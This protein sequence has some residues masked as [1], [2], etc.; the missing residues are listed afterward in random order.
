MSLLIERLVYATDLTDLSTQVTN[1]D[2]V[3]LDSQVAYLTASYE[4]Y[5]LNSGSDGTSTAHWT[6]IETSSSEIN[7][8]RS[9]ET[10]VTITS[11]DSPYTVPSWE[12]LVKA[13]A[14]SGVITVNLPTAV[15]N[16]SKKIS[17]IKID[18]S[19]NAITVNGNSPETIN[20]GSDSLPSQW[21]SGQYYS[22]GTNVL[23]F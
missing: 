20:G 15:G 18:S 9:L 7:T 6:I 2:I 10:I 19:G 1:G 5:R 11:A 23:K 17:I 21:D 4:L 12:Y 13:D 3:V 14:S 16:G 22:D 8:K